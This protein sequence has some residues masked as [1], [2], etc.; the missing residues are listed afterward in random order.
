M[1]WFD[2]C[3]NLDGVIK[4]S[5]E[6]SMEEVDIWQE[7]GF[8]MISVVEDLILGWLPEQS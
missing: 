2:C 6:D 4:T 5:R 3:M 1:L 7:F 8:K